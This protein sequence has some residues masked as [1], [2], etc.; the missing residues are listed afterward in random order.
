MALWLQASAWGSLQSLPVAVGCEH[1]R[2]SGYRGRLVLAEVHELSDQIRDL[3][4]N[5]CSM[6]ELKQSVYVEASNRLSVAALRKVQE[7]LTTVEE[8]RRVVGME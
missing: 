6:T 2:A 4:V 1:C 7:G 8:V 3:I 5:K